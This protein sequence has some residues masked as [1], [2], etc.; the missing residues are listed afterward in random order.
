MTPCKNNKGK[1]RR[2]TYDGKTSPVTLTASAAGGASTEVKSRSPK[3]GRKAAY[4]RNVHLDFSG[5]DKAMML[6]SLPSS[7]LRGTDEKSSAFAPEVL[8]FARS[9]FSADRTYKFRVTYNSYF[10]TS[11]SGVI[12]GAI[13]FSPS[14]VSFAEW[15]CLSALFDEV[16]LRTCK[17]TLTGATNNSASAVAI[18][19]ASNWANTSSAPSGPTAVL[20]LP[21]SEILNSYFMSHSTS[22]GVF[23]KTVK[24]PIKV[25]AETATPAVVSPPAG[26]LGTFD[27][28]G[29]NSSSSFSIPYFYY[30]Q[31][32]ILEL[33]CRA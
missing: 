14:V 12:N 17:V 15:S 25:W 5:F 31:E 18:A 22:P 27:I 9:L 24:S 11:G 29:L 1:G 30:F 8:E 2:I 23:V 21:D 20:R 26:C 16:R 33:R 3:G 28:V 19:I 13:S 4:R 32:Q 6:L 10:A 7:K